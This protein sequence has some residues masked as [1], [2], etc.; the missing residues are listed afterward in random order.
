MYGYID[1]I[2][3]LYN[4]CFSYALVDSDL[5][6]GRVP[7]VVVFLAVV[8]SL[9]SSALYTQTIANLKIAPGRVILSGH[10]KAGNK[11][12]GFLPAF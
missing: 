5:V 3:W 1:L 10:R 8:S 11:Q 6:F 2:V 9:P 4:I 7:V 12:L